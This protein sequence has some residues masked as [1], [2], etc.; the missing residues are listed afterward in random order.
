MSTSSR[1][2]FRNNCRLL[3]V[4]NLLKIYEAMSTTPKKPE[5][6]EIQRPNLPRERWLE[7]VYEGLCHYCGKPANETEEKN[8]RSYAVS[9]AENYYDD[10]TAR[11]SPADAVMDELSSST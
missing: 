4:H 7:L 6:L 1:E 8:L 11:L 10:P 5:N 3:E 9:L 2:W